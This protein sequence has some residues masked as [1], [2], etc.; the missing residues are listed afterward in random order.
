MTASTVPCINIPPAPQR[1]NVEVAPS[2]RALLAYL[3]AKIHRVDPDLLV[4]RQM[5]TD[6]PTPTVCGSHC[7]DT[8]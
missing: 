3:L 2:E 1:F 4:V 7:R 5:A 6:Y 8:T